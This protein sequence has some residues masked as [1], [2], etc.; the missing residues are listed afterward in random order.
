MKYKII[1]F[2]TFFLF[3]T[4]I[5]Q[6]KKAKVKKKS[7]FNYEKGYHRFIGAPI[8]GYLYDEKSTSQVI[9]GGVELGYGFFPRNNWS[10]SFSTSGSYIANRPVIDANS[11]NFT[12]DN[13]YYFF[14]KKRV[15]LIFGIDASVFIW[16][17]I[18]DPKYLDYV[19]Y[20]DVADNTLKTHVIPNISA[21]TGLSIKISKRFTMPF[22]IGYRYNFHPYKTGRTPGPKFL[23]LNFG[24]YYNFRSLKRPKEKEIKF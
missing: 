15:S 8:L 14:P 16:N 17:Y 9:L 23:Y 5:S 13:T 22:K 18:P 1:L 12:L 20:E 3:S 7:F 21:Y 11:F 4:S 6:I 24:F 2:F 19:F 10:I